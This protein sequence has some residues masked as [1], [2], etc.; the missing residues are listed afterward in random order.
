MELRVLPSELRAPRSG[1][2]RVWTERGKGRCR[3]WDERAAGRHLARRE[4]TQASRRESLR[5]RRPRSR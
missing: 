2:G 3:A 4:S 5:A 1:S